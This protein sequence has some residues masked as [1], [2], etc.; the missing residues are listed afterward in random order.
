MIRRTWLPRIGFACERITPR[1]ADIEG[2]QWAGTAARAAAANR[3]DTEQ[4]EEHVLRTPEA[5]Q[6]VLAS[7]S[8][9]I[10]ANAKHT[11]PALQLSS[12]PYVSFLWGLNSSFRPQCSLPE[13]SF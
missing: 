3:T 11:L 4:G 5:M 1:A 13:L 12:K 8:D 6:A 7:S 10:S 9:Q 2:Y